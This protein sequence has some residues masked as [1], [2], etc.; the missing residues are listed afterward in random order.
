MAKSDAIDMVDLVQ[1]ATFIFTGTVSAV[2]ASALPVVPNGPDVVVAR[3]ERALQVNPML[4]DLTGQPITIRLAR[5]SK[6]GFGER[7]IFFANSWIHGETVAVTEV[8]H[9]PADK[10]TE[11][12]V[13]SAMRSLPERHLQE[14]VAS[15]SL[16]VLATVR[17]VAAAGIREPATEHAADWQRASLE[18]ES[19][20]K[21]E[22][23]EATGGAR[24]S[25]QSRAL[26]VV[27]PASLDKAWREWPKLTNGQS[28]IF[29]LRPATV[30]RLPPDNL[31]AP[32]PAD[33]QPPSEAQ[34]ISA[35]V[36][37]AKP[38]DG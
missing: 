25:R 19:V 12:A 14:R 21:G 23:P 10:V 15:A 17:R 38:P 18:V 8:A 29:L 20:L 34:A 7:W 24:R 5:G 27:F 4:G 31:V 2:S 16:I 30:P 13:T 26:D 1:A 32:D 9:L 36:R 35:L 3:F 22:L 33:V 11:D 28:A 37:G 6:L